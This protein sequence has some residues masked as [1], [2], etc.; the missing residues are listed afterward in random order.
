MYMKHQN[1]IIRTQE[2]LPSSKELC[3]DQCETLR[4]LYQ[5]CNLKF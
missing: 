4:V 1:L 5:D 3:D 2:L